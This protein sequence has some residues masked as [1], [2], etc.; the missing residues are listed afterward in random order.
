[1]QFW[2]GQVPMFWIPKGWIPYYAEW[3][4]SFP[5][6][7]LGSISINIWFVACASAVQI[8]SAALAAIWAL[9][10]QGVQDSTQEKP[11]KMS[12][13]GEKNSGTKKEL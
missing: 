5:K 9:R 7:P 11:L 4:L 12:V 2:Y 13:V 3:L 6:A 8:V 10:L 1:M